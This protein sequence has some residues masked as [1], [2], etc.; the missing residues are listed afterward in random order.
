LDEKVLRS[1]ELHCHLRLPLKSQ[2]VFFHAEL[3]LLSFQVA[4]KTKEE[5]HY[6][7]WGLRPLIDQDMDQYLVSFQTLLILLFLY[8]IV[9]VVF[10]VFNGL[11][12]IRI[13]CKLFFNSCDSCY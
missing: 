2:M 10:I 3:S 7:D 6:T 11:D 13:L 1:K 9:V 5:F 8:F 4:L 12:L